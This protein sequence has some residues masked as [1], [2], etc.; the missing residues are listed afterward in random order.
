MTYVHIALR[1]I[2]LYVLLIYLFRN[3]SACFELDMV[4]IQH[5]QDA[6]AAQIHIA[7][8]LS[9]T[10]MFVLPIIAGTFATM[11]VFLTL[12]LLSLISFQSIPT[13]DWCSFPSIASYLGD[14]IDIGMN[15]AP[16]VTCCAVTSAGFFILALLV[17]L[18]YYAV[19]F[20]NGSY[21]LPAMDARVVSRELVLKCR[22]V[23]YCFFTAIFHAAPS[24]PCYATA[25]RLC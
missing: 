14:L 22:R 5:V 10:T 24:C 17:F 23:S 20:D 9:T 2:S 8:F 19:Q 18:C 4:E 16:R 15:V 3:P 1:S 7:T 13:I 12:P 25:R 11:S 21:Q 6:T